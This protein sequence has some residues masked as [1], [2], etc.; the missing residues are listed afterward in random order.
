MAAPTAD[1]PDPAPFRIDLTG[2]QPGSFVEGTGG[3]RTGVSATVITRIDGSD[4]GL[5]SVVGL[6]VFRL[7]RDPDAP[8]RSWQSSGSVDG[9]GPI[10]MG[11][12]D[13]ITATVRFACPSDPAQDTFDAVVHV[14]RQDEQTQ[15]VL[16]IPIHAALPLKALA[17]RMPTLPR[18]SMSSSPERRRPY[19]MMFPHRFASKR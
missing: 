18:T 3:G 9:G 11:S 6:E 12:Q 17:L 13:F 10:G 4:S 2:V 19:I 15:S 7:E 8:K 5:F 14:S 1:P 16:S